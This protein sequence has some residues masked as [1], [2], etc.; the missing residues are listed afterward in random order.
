VILDLPQYGSDTAK[1]DSHANGS[2]SFRQAILSFC[3]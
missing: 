3:A 2:A 1:A